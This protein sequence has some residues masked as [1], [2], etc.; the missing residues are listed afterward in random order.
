MGFEN[1]IEGDG[2]GLAV[3]GMVIVFLGLIFISLYISSL[4]RLA[5]MI[6]RW[7]ERQKVPAT[8]PKAPAETTGL[9]DPALWAAIGLVVEAEMVNHQALDDQRITIQH[10]ESQG[11]WAFAGKMR[12][13]S[14]RM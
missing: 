10:D 1:V 8:A 4:P 2:I 6:D 3:T 14:T 7:R 5:G 12:T 13:L 9:D 11:A